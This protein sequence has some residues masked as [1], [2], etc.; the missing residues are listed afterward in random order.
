MV[1]F[2]RIIN[3]YAADQRFSKYDYRQKAAM[4]WNYRDEGSVGERLKSWVAH[5][6]LRHFGN[7][8]FFKRFFF[9]IL[10]LI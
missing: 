3:G 4:H 5:G 8:V 10:I 6:G 2:R 9:V 1:T 7:Y